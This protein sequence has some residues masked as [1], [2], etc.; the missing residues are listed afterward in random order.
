MDALT[1]TLAT[2]SAMIT[3]AVLVSGCGSLLLTTSQRLAR[4]MERTRSIV[5]RLE[6]LQTASS[7]GSLLVEERAMLVSQLRRSARRARVLQRVMTCLYVALGSFVAT[8]VAVGVMTLWAVKW[9]W[10][11]LACGLGGSV[12]LL[13]GSIFLIY[14]SQLA[15]RVIDDE[16]VFLTALGEHHAGSTAE[17]QTSTARA[18]D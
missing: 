4:L 3:P 5:R 14:E 12:L 10:I 2:L 6:Q 9:A 7:T 18:T 17:S 1:T 15:L 8:T 11:P 16:M 13:V